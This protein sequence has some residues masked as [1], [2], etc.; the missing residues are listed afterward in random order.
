MRLK[1][2]GQGFTESSNRVFE[3]SR[4]APDQNGVGRGQLWLRYAP[5]YLSQFTFIAF[6]YDRKPIK[7]CIDDGKAAARRA[8]YGSTAGSS[9]DQYLSTSRVEDGG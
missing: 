3:F 5:K 6:R 4:L 9:C 8:S 7:R 1:A 2:A